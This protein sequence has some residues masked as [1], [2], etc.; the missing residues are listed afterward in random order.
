MGG[1]PTANRQTTRV[2]TSRRSRCWVFEPALRSHHFTNAQLASGS[3]STSLIGKSFG[4]STSCVILLQDSTVF[5]RGFLGWEL[6]SSINQ[7]LVSSIYPLSPPPPHKRAAIMPV[8]KK[9]APK[10]HADFRLISITPVFT[11]ILERIIVHKF[12]HQLCSL[13]QQLYHSNISTQ[14]AKL[15]LQVHFSYYISLTHGHKHAHCQSI[16]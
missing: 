2:R 13:P 16:M 5:Q 14:S 8:P 10:E 7:S 4:Y 15:A 9:S 6:R 12:I 1:I 3:S 11:R